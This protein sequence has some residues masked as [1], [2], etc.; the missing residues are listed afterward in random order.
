MSYNDFRTHMQKTA[1]MGYAIAV[2]SWDQE[3][4]MPEKGAEFR[5][6]Q[7][8]TLSGVYHKMITD[9]ALGKLLKEL[10][11]DTSLTEK[12]KKNVELTQETYEK[13]KKFSTDFVE[14]M[15]KTV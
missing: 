3:T 1:D 9:E 4:Y 15:S 13:Q 12:Q 6:Q 11:V 2:L 10:S 14:L 7:L 5:A 8:S